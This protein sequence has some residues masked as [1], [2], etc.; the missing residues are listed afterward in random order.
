MRRWQFWW[1]FDKADQGTHGATPG[2]HNPHNSW[3]G[4]RFACASDQIPKLDVA[5]STPVARSS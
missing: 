4:P 5:G 3:N 1:Q 2:S